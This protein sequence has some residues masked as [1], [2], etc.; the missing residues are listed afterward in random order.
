M[1]DIPPLNVGYLLKK[2]G[3]K[4][5]KGL[6]Q[7]FLQDPIALEK[8]ASAAQIQPTDTVLEIGPGLGSLTR[9]LA[10]AAKEVVA[11]ELDQH[12]LPPLK[13]VLAPYPN[14]RLIHGDILELSPADL[15][16][17]P[18]YIVAAN[19]PYY[20]TSALIRHLLE[21]DTKP[22]RVVL[23]IQKEVARRICETPGDMSLLALS[24]QVYGEPYIAAHIPAGAFFPSPNVDSSVL[25]I[26]MYPAP[27]IPRELLGTFFKLI[28]AGFGQKRKTLRNSLSSGLS[29]SPIQAADLLERNGI[30]PQ[31]RAE[32]LSIEEW[33][34][35]AENLL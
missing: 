7:N 10:A 35:L 3:L 22:R 21:S 5:H 8:I 30:D 6:G 32:T 27:R 29:I 25:V 4:P 17:E 13:S 12:L 14:V 23:T 15:I 11:V 1:N 24:V 19:I 9:Y 28:K 34:R 33:Q 18:G 31:R 16:P 2:Y 26:D 20:I